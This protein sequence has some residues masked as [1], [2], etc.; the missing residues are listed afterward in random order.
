M[1]SREPAAKSVQRLYPLAVIVHLQSSPPRVPQSFVLPVTPT[2]ASNLMSQ[3]P[4]SGACLQTF[5][6]VPRL[7]TQR[8]EQHDRSL[9]RPQRVPLGEHSVTSSPVTD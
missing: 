4:C 6:R 8:P 5:F 2:Q 1:Q 3:M 7:R 9:I